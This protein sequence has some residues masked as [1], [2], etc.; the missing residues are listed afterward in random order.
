MLP[1]RPGQMQEIERTGFLKHDHIATYLTTMLVWSASIGAA[2]KQ[3]NILCN[4]ISH[5][6]QRNFSQEHLNTTVSDYSYS[7]RI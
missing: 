4:I 5:A 6:E 7:I 2:Y 1:K 3:N